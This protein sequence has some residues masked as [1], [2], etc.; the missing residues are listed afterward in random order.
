MA[1]VNIL[2]EILDW[3]SDRPNWQRDALR[4]LVLHGDL[5]KSDIEELAVLCKE[6]HGLSSKVEPQPLAKQHLPVSDAAVTPVSLTSLT[7]HSGVNA[8]AHDQT[9]ASRLPLMNSS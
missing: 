7:H 2:R 9:V 4:R 3:S 1:K 6:R 8:L 5:Q